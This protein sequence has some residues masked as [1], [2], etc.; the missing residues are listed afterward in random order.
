MCR[1]M[2]MHDEEQ[3]V[4]ITYTA[5]TTHNLVVIDANS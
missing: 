1:E 2:C 5:S 4:P 3:F